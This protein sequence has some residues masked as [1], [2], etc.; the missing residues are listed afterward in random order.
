MPANNPLAHAADSHGEPS[1]SH[2]N[3]A[4]TPRDFAEIY[5]RC[6]GFV[7]ACTRRFGIAEA[8]MEDVVQEIFVVIYGRLHTLERPDAFRSWVYGIVRRT[9]SSY[10]R[11]KRTRA[12]NVEAFRSEPEM[13]YPQMPSPLELAEQADQ[14]RLLWP[15]IEGLDPPKRE[16]FVLS[17]LDDMTVPEIAAAIS[18]PINTVYSRIR[19]AR[20]ELDRALEERER[21]P[22]RG[23]PWRT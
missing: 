1:T 4:K 9:A 19:A 8:E 21:A 18:T 16:A 14:V 3:C 2:S 10:H 7:W 5:T 20:Q 17:E 13:A 23:Q 6:F 22:Q 11:A 12:A 15:L